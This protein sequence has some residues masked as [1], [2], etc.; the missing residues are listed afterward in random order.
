MIYAVITPLPDDEGSKC[1]PITPPYGT[2]EVAS[3]HSGR[4]L[5]RDPPHDSKL[6]YGTLLAWIS[7]FSADST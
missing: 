6:F 7:A 2:L 1:T 4:P 5:D 3:L